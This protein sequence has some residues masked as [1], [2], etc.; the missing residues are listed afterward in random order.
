MKYIF[1]INAIAGRGKYKKILPNI[2][3]ACKKRNVEY[4]IRYISAEKDGSQIALEYKNEENI[5]YVVGGDGTINFFVNE[6]KD[7]D[8]TFD[9]YVYAA[10]TGNDFLKDVEKDIDSD[11]LLHLNKYIKNLPT[12]TINGKET[13]FIN[14]IGY[15]I[16]GE[17]CRVADE[18]KAK[19]KKKINYTSISIKLALFK[20]RRPTATIKVDGNVITR[21]KVFLAS[22][23]NGR[24]YGGGMFVAPQQD[25]LGGKLTMVCMHS[26]S[27]IKALMIF[28]SIFTGG[29]IKHKKQV[30]VI[31]GKEIEVIF[32]RTTSLQI[33][34]ETVLNVTSYKAKI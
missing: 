24:Y 2:E 34:G 8:V 7:L 33:D 15:G 27:R 30:D 13:R 4:E 31:E 17:A 14:G 20:Y 5:I 21:K 19:G 25:R 28:A 11:G 29:H 10:G 26:Y 22:A 18:M 23:M 16:D 9:A 3:Q 32:N 6:I 12:V 1:I